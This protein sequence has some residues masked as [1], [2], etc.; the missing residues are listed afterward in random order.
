MSN[1]TLHITNGGSLTGYL[2]ELDFKDDIL[3]WHEMLCEG[4]TYNLLD[5]K[6]FIN[7]RKAFLSTYYDIEFD[8]QLYHKELNVLNNTNAYNEIVLWFEYDLFCHIN[9]IAVISLLQEKKINLPLFLVCSGRVE[10]EPNLK[11]LSELS[12]NMLMAHYENKIQLT[13]DDIELARDIWRTYCGKDHNLL[14]PYITKK[15]S[16][17]YLNSCLKAHLKRFPNLKNGLSDLEENILKIIKDNDIK[18]R[19]HL[20]GYA[21]NYQ[22]Y[23]GFGDIQINRLINNLAIFFNE[24]ESSITLNRKGYEALHGQSNFALEINNNIPF[25]GVNRLDFYFSNEENKLIKNPIP[26]RLKNLNLY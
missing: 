17:K 19:H 2:K 1:N 24:S 14:K 16:F 4:N 26:C 5:S 8:E 7:Q 18:S 15:S 6:Q 22:G 11:G 23:Y 3:T 9:L 12:H 25:G 21:L 10:G 13:S 20:L